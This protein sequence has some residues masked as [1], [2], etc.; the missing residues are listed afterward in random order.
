[1]KQDDVIRI[2][3]SPNDGTNA[4]LCASVHRYN[5]ADEVQRIM[6]WGCKITRIEASAKFEERMVG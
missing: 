6:R 1:M 3:Y 2:Y 5:A 4:V